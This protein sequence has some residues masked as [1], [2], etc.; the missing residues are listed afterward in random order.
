MCGCSFSRSIRLFLFAESDITLLQ[1]DDVRD[2][3]HLLS[4]N[5]AVLSPATITPYSNCVVD[6]SYLTVVVVATMT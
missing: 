1:C 3:M 4:C 2:L 6:S 5:L